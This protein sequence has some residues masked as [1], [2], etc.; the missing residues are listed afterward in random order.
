MT[1]THPKFDEPTGDFGLSTLYNLVYC[2][3][4]AAVLD[5]GAV[6]DIIAVAQRRN[7]LHGITGLLVFGGGI[8][9]QWLE[10]P[11]KMKRVCRHCSACLNS[12][13]LAASA[14][15]PAEAAFLSLPLCDER[16]LSID[17]KTRRLKERLCTALL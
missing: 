10:A 2:S 6:D 8:F 11:R 7:P 12:S 17:G 3:R 13:S 14:G 1:E 4:A 16:H 15:K 9:F 5:K